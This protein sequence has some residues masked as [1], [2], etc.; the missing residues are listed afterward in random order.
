MSNMDYFYDSQIRRYLLQLIRAFSFFE[1][2]ATDSNGNTI[3]RRVPV[4]YAD[5]SRMVA[6]IMKGNSENIL[7]SA[8]MMSLGITALK[9]DPTMRHAPGYVDRRQVAEREYNAVTGAYT[10]NQGNLYTIERHMP[11]PYIMT[12]QLDIWTTNTTNKLELLEQLLVIFNP[13]IQIQSNDNPLD[14]TS[15]FEIELTDVN[16]SNRGIPAGT[17]TTIEYATLTFDNTVFINPPAKVQRQKIIQQIVTNIHS[18]TDVQDLNFEFDRYYDFFANINEDSRLIVTPNDLEIIVS[19]GTLELVNSADEGQS[20]S[21]L[22]EMKGDISSSSRVELNLRNDIEDR[23]ELVYGTVAFTGDDTILNFTVD[24]DTLPGDTL[25]PV[26]VID[27]NNF[28]PDNT[29]GVRYLL[30]N[31]DILANTTAS[32]VWNTTAK[33]GNILEYDSNTWSVAFT[34]S[35]NTEYVSSSISGTQFKWTGSEWL[36]SY[37]GQYRAGYFRLIL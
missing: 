20:W 19:N 8:P 36:D 17:D 16:W 21:D 29:D 13:N 6:Q 4:R 26:R 24:T 27:P 22:I 15:V 25:D 10:Q 12:T 33:V 30:V 2:Q 18:V 5:P 1:V 14:W 28:T 23:S 3:Q 32:N 37:Q 34:T 9:Q 35:S 11:V 7:N 31:N